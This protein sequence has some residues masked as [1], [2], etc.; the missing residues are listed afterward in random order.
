MEAFCPT[1]FFLLRVFWSLNVVDP[2]FNCISASAPQSSQLSARTGWGNLLETI[3]TETTMV[4]SLRLTQLLFCLLS[5]H[6]SSCVALTETMWSGRRRFAWRG[7]SIFHALS[8]C[9]HTE[10]SF[11]VTCRMS[12]LG[13]PMICKF[14]FITN[15]QK[16]FWGPLTAVSRTNTRQE[17]DWKRRQC[18]RCGA[19]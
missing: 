10:L 5:R 2:G 17:I 9:A 6:T 8:F 4:S 1:S 16:T 12:G 18:R 19:V 11:N 13:S 3:I 7:A 14:L 15:K